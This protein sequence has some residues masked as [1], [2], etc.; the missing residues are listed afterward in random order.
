MTYNDNPSATP[1]VGFSYKL[2]KAK[3]LSA[4]D[5]KALQGPKEPKAKKSRSGSGRKPKAPVRITSLGKYP[6]ITSKNPLRA[7]T[8]TETI[9]G[10]AVG[11]KVLQRVSAE[12]LK[13]G[14]VTL[15]GADAGAAFAPA[16]LA[17]AVSYYLTKKLFEFH[18]ITK[19]TLRENA[20]RA[21]E[22]YKALRRAWEEK[23]GR[24]PKGGT[25]PRLTDAQYRKLAKV[26][27]DELLSYGLST[28]DLTRI[29]G[30]SAYDPTPPPPSRDQ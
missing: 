29:Q 3:R 18:A 7:P 4:A 16:V 23:Y 13:R 27:Q 12:V 5:K 17:A 10:A 15:A 6:K 28:N 1:I 8:A 2:P 11:P 21:A 24:V 14:A 20:F 25:T 19:A 26:F 9:L 30:R 22:A